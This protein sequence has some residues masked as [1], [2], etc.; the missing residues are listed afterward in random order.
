MTNGIL[1]R[2]N[3]RLRK[4][5][6]DKKRKAGQSGLLTS[7]GEVMAQRWL[8]HL[9]T[10]Y[11]GRRHTMRLKVPG[12]SVVEDTRSRTFAEL[13][14]LWLTGRITEGPGIC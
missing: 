13:F 5:K 14:E 6:K 11:K 9:H 10:K 7:D 1:R 8:L 4:D 2:D 12:L 3:G